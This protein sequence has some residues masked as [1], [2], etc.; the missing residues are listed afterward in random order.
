MASDDDDVDDDGIPR[1]H[2][3]VRDPSSINATS[4]KPGAQDKD[5]VVKKNLNM[6][7]VY[8]AEKKKDNT[9]DIMLSAKSITT[10]TKPT[11]A[12]KN[13]DSMKSSKSSSANSPVHIAPRPSP[14]QARPPP[15]SLPKASPSNSRPQH[16]PLIRTPLTIGGSSSIV[17]KPQP[18]TANNSTTPRQQQVPVI[19]NAKSL[20]LQNSPSSSSPF[21]LQ[22]KIPN[23]PA[24]S[25]SNAASPTLPRGSIAAQQLR[26]LQQRMTSAGTSSNLINSDNNSYLAMAKAKKQLHLAQLQL[27]QRQRQQQS[28]NRPVP[29]GIFPSQATT[30]TTTTTSIVNQ[31]QQLPKALASTSPGA[32]RLTM[33]GSKPPAGTNMS[34]LSDSVS[35]TKITST[36]QRIAISNPP[37]STVAAAG[38]NNAAAMSFL[39]GNLGR[40]QDL[41]ITKTIGG[42]AGTAVRKVLPG[43]NM[44]VKTSQD[45]T[46]APSLK[47][48]L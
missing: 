33:T 18:A 13:V 19:T 41:V 28:P 17:A 15:Y 38:T 2:I 31:Q 11:I 9:K 25:S 16:P 20:Q 39:S 45:M 24:A 43:P 6:G 37:S 4:A 21:S 40:K 1:P 46:V 47:R 44:V 5:K 34:P 42:G 22:Q 35:I 30:T 36:G 29:V 8:P 48:P 7:I 23:P 3:I 27:A 12:V 26:E 10:L 14:K 32:A